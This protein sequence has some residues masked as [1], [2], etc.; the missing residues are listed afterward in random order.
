MTLRPLVS[1]SGRLSDNGSGWGM[2]SPVN[3][4]ST[5]LLLELALQIGITV[6]HKLVYG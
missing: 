1:Q 4:H 3:R 6:S 5:G 2:L